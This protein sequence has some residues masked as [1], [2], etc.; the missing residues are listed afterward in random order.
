LGSLKI[1]LTEEEKNEIREIADIADISQG[2]DRYP[3]GGIGLLL[4]DT[5]PLKE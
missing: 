5:P 1:K 3:A 4:K 2:G